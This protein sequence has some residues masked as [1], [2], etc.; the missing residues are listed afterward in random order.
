MI[1]TASTCSLMAFDYLRVREITSETHYKAA[2]RMFKCFCLNGGFYIKFGQ[3]MGQ[4]QSLIPDEYLEVFEPMCQQAPTT[5]WKDVKSVVEL[6]L[7]KPISQVFSEFDE[8]PFASA[9]LG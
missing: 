7:G 4:L 3:M 6:E 1:R 9:S 5:C 8:K 2:N